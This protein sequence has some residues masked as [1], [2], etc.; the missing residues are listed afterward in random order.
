MSGGGKCEVE[1]G[2]Q[3]ALT[4][5]HYEENTFIIFAVTAFCFLTKAGVGHVDLKEGQQS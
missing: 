5:T 3:N 2:S 1:L 4:Q